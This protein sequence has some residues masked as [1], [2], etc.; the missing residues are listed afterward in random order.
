VPTYR[1]PGDNVDAAGSGGRPIEGVATAVPAFVGIS[2]AGPTNVPALVTSWSRFTSLF[3]DP[4]EGWFLALAVYGYFENGGGSCYVVSMGPSWPEGPAATAGADAFSR[5]STVD[6][7]TM[8]SVPDL[9]SAYLHG[10]VDLDGIRAVQLAAIAHCESMGDRLA[11]LDTPPELDANQVRQW[12]RGLAAYDSAFACMY[13]P[14]IEVADLD[15]GAKVFVPPSGH[16]AGIWGRNDDTLGV[17]KAPANQPIQGAISV[18]SDVSGKEE[19]LLDP[20]GVNCIRTLPGRGIRV[21]GARTL[22]ADQDWRYI[23]VRRLMNYLE[24]SIFEGTSW[25]A[26]E[27]REP[28]LWA[29]IQQSVSTFLTGEWRKG[30]LFG[31]TPDQRFYVKC[32]ADTNPPDVS[33]AGEVVIEIGVS[34]VKPGEFLIFRISQLSATPG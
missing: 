20:V 26:A 16:M 21:W 34:P 25:A 1:S 28:D 17:H 8:V 2:S 27:P 32:D 29:A 31:T 18:E 9:M 12:R 11:I 5:L 19:G 22:S 10:S 13:W 3:G 6:G 23:N 14:W 4:V 24:Q 30:A 7:I 33:A 15:S